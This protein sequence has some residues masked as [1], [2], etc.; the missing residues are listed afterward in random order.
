MI[1]HLLAENA[2]EG[3]RMQAALPSDH[4]FTRYLHQVGAFETTTH[5]WSSDTVRQ[6]E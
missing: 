3:G 4:G 6:K 2:G 1:A 5:T